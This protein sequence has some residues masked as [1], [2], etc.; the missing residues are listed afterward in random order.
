M[1]AHS[2]RTQLRALSGFVVDE[3][4]TAATNLA[5]KQY[6]FVSPG[7]IAGE[8]V[9]ST[10]A[11]LPMPI[12]VLQNTPTAGQPARVRVFGRT[13]LTACT[14]ACNLMFGTFLTSG[15][16]GNALPSVCGLVLARWASASAVSTGCVSTCA[17]GALVN[18]LAGFGTCIGAAS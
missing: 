3:T 14:G 1:P 5:T 17:N 8:V 12:G 9:L 13:T 6:Y 4:F 10:G 2:V 7:S 16:A 11:S 15:S 18:C